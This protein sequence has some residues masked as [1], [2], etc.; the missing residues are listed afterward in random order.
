MKDD[1]GRLMVAEGISYSRDCLE[2]GL[3]NNVL[4]VG[5]SGTGK[6]RSIVTPNLLQ[7]VGSYVVSDPKGTLYDEYGDY[8]EAKGYVVDK[9]DFTDPKY[10]AH[11]NFLR[12]IKS[13]QDIVKI[14]HM[15]VYDPESRN[16][17]SKDPFWDQAAQLL[18]ESLIA[19]LLE[20]VPENE[21]TL[22]GMLTML[23]ACHVEEDRA[24]EKNGL[25]LLMDEFKKQNPDS[26]AVRHYQRFR[27]AASRTLMSILITATSKLAAYDTAELREMLSRD[28]VDIASIGRRKTAL[29]VV[30]SDTDRSLDNLVNLFFSQALNELCREADSHMF[31][32]RLA[33][34][35]QFILD[36]FATNCKIE[37]FPRMIASIRSRGISAMLMIQAESQLEQLYEEDGRTIIG[38]CDTYIYMGGNDLKTADSVAKRCNLP[39]QKIFSM[40]VG[41]SWIFRRGQAPVKGRNIDLDKFKSD[42]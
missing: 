16:G 21:Q 19:A 3:N 27:L 17:K 35:V 23:D 37:D 1:A 32:G 30:V 7:A 10:S 38:N 39:L 18:F 40:P 36:D 33:V 41:T 20:F 15:L 4:V 26:F 25:D 28:D 8:L 34:P 5:A 14:A 29:F 24:D 2:T 22:Q 13:E 42:L 31:D 12:Y 11:Y 6:T 9:L